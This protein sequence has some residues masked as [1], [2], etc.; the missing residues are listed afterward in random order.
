MLLM[1]Y[2]IFAYIQYQ[3]AQF[4]RIPCI[5]NFPRHIRIRTS[6]LYDLDNNSVTASDD[7]G[8]S[9]GH[10]M[11]LNRDYCSVNTDEDSIVE[12]LTEVP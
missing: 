9:L 6:A 3:L 10:N 4:F 12:E 1:A 2:T 7:A 5:S 11:A 8:S